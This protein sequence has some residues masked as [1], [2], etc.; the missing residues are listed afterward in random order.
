MISPFD[1][2]DAVAETRPAVRELG[3]KAIFLR[4]NSVNGRNRHDP[5]YEP[6]WSELEAL[7]VPLGF[8]EDEVTRPVMKATL[9]EALKER[10]K[11]RRA[12]WFS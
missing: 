11:I 10:E 8:H 5:Y 2:D 12:G 9:V 6:L 1:V 3:F 7:E 4:P